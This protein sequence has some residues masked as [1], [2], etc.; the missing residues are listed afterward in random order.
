MS[1]KPKNW[2]VTMLVSETK[3]TGNVAFSE[4]LVK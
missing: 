4:A 1:E 2:G 3:P